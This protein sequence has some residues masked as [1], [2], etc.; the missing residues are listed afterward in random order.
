MIVKHHKILTSQKLGCPLGSLSSKSFQGFVTLARLENGTYCLSSVLIGHKNGIAAYF[1][2][3]NMSNM[4]KSSENIKKNIKMPQEYR[5][6]K[7]KCY[8]T[9]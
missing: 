3:K 8:Y 7:V 6:K 2:K 5:I 4:T 9:E 1:C